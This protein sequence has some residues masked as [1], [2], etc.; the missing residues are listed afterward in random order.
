M[1]QGRLNLWFIFA[2]VFV[3]LIITMYTLSKSSYLQKALFASA[4][5]LSTL[6]M[7]PT[8]CQEQTWS[9]KGFKLPKF[10]TI[11]P[12]MLERAVDKELVRFEGN[13]ASLNREIGRTCRDHPGAAV[14]ALE[15][16]TMPLEKEW[17]LVSHLMGVQNSDDIR[18]VHKTLQQKVIKAHQGVWLWY[19]SSAL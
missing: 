13:L 16:L 18:S 6:K 17:G 14:S 8:Y 10:S 2:F 1:K 11:T 9:A 19:C 5:G 7:S 12:T 4:A 3:A 15:M